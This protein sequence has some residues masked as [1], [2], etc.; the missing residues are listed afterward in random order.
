[1]ASRSRCHKPW[2]LHQERAAVR[3]L[4]PVSTGHSDRYGGGLTRRTQS[5]A[6]VGMDWET[7]EQD[8]NGGP[9]A[10][11]L[12]QVSG[13]IPLPP[14]AQ[15][16]YAGRGPRSPMPFPV[17]AEAA[18]PA[19]DGARDSCHRQRHGADSPPP[20]RPT[21]T[22]LAPAARDARPPC[23]APC[24][25]RPAPPLVGRLSSRHGAPPQP[26]SRPGG[27]APRHTRAPDLEDIPSTTREEFI[28]WPGG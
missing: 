1:M 26:D 17:G 11:R 7:S 21:S 12:S 14:P 13:T 16:A 9:A 24:R 19:D 3:P 23:A 2:S 8:I 22:L 27:G 20:P 28:T 15:A 18:P 4:G 6:A 10:R 5:P 25:R